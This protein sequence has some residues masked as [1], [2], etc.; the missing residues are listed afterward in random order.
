MS[1]I[2][3]KKTLQDENKKQ[4]KHAKA[5]FSKVGDTIFVICNTIFLILFCIVT[6]YPVLNTVA[7]SFNDGTDAIRGNI[8]LLPRMFSLKNYATVLG[9]ET[10]V[11][12]AIVTVARTILGTLF[13]LFTNALLAFIV[14]RKK[15]LFKSQL[16]LFWVLTMYINGGLIP[17]LLLYKNLGLTSSFWVYVIP[18][19]ISAFNMLVIRTFMQGI[20][21]SLE[22]SAQLDGAG[23][24]TI[25]IRIISPLCMPVYATVALFVAVYQWNSWFDAMLYN[26]MNTKYTTLQ[27]ELMKLLSSVMQQGGNANQ[28]AVGESANTVT[29]VTVR[30]AAT[31]V[32]MLPIIMLYPF[33]QRY[34]VTGLTIGGV[35]E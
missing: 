7:I 27:Y 3:E 16:S 25:F 30:A 26:R 17:V 14:S 29:P 4:L 23:Y 8:Y 33:L 11:T 12:A 35:K 15:F 28:G 9:K 20:P 10:M 18:G 6:L 22:E 19:M 34:F 32:T 21:D 1:K 13:A 24:F 31:V 5:D 2:E